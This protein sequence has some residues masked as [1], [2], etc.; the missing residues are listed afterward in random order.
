MAGAG[1]IP[2]ASSWAALRSVRSRRSRRIVVDGQR[3]QVGDP[4]EGLM[5]VLQRHPLPQRAQEVAEVQRVGGR[6][7]QG[8][9]A[10]TAGRRQDMPSFFHGPAAR[11]AGIASW[12]VTGVDRCRHAAGARLHA[13]GRPAGR[14]GDRPA[15]SPSA[16]AGR[17][18]RRARPR[19]RSTSTVA[20]RSGADRAAAMKNPA[21]V[22]YG[23]SGSTSPVFSAKSSSVVRP[24]TSSGRRVR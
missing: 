21:S 6:L 12:P 10:A 14:P 24:S 5:I 2:A 20:R 7:G 15:R 23:P 19:P 18:R 16:R 13:A 1:S 9:R 17:S 11:Q 4:V 8:E 3:V 22:S